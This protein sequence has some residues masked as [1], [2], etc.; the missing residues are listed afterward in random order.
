MIVQFFIYGKSGN[1]IVYRQSKNTFFRNATLIEA[2]EYNKALA[3]F[4]Q[5]RLKK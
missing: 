3:Y 2:D 1:K 5:E 4:N